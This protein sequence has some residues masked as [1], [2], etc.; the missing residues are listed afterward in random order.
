M[1]PADGGDDGGQRQVVMN[2]ILFLKGTVCANHPFTSSGEEEIQCG[3]LPPQRLT[4]PLT[5]GPFFYRFGW[6]ITWA[7]EVCPSMPTLLN[8]FFQS[9]T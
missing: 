6:V 4:P 1:L 9:V 3:G 8:M 2:F 5:T 7:M